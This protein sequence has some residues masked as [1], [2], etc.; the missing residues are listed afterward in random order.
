MRDV[1]LVPEL[2]LQAGR[3]SILLL[4]A[5]DTSWAVDTLNNNLQPKGCEPC[6]YEIK[7]KA[8]DKKEYG[9]VLSLYKSW[10]GSLQCS[11]PPDIRDL[12]SPP[13]RGKVVLIL[14]LLL[15]LAKLAGCPRPT[16]RENGLMERKCRLMS[17]HGRA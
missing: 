13:T 7:F 2:A 14:V 9:Q 11:R 17:H 8:E 15:S 10:G 4:P 3:L 16:R 12:G 5:Q 6:C 1:C